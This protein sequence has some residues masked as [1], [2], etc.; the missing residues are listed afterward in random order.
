MDGARRSSLAILLD[1]V[2][3]IG[4]CERSIDITREIK[5]A[6]CEPTLRAL[7]RGIMCEVGQSAIERI[8]R[9]IRIGH[10]EAQHRLALHKQTKAVME[11]APPERGAVEQMAN[12]LKRI[13]DGGIGCGFRK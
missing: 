9:E 7:R 10:P 2:A 8:R 1:E 11:H 3:P 5:V 6:K 4:E 13:L 12:L